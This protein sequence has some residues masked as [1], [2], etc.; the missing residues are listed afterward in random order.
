MIKWVQE[1]TSCEVISMTIFSCYMPHALSRQT[2]R[3]WG[4][5]YFLDL[6]THPQ[7]R[8]CQLCFPFLPTRP[9]RTNGQAIIQ[10]MHPTQPLKPLRSCIMYSIWSLPHFGQRLTY[11]AIIIYSFLNSAKFFKP[12]KY[13]RLPR[14]FGCRRFLTSG[15]LRIRYLDSA[16]TK[17]RCNHAWAF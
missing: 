8:Q 6:K 5:F 1:K 17:L 7:F 13:L 12:Y 14:L 2:L 9:R 11:L 15:F 3:A 4:F 16:S 10:P